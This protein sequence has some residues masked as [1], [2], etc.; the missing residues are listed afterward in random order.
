MIRCSST[1]SLIS[2]SLSFCYGYEPKPI[3]WSLNVVYIIRYSF[4]IRL[5]V[6]LTINIVDSGHGGQTRDLD[7]DEVDGWDE[8]LYS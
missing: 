2:A 1:V 5:Y 4:Y 3:L 6:D 7:G 8:G